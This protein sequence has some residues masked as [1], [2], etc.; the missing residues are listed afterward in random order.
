LDGVGADGKQQKLF[1]SSPTWAIFIAYDRPT[2]VSQIVASLNAPGIP[3]HT[4]LVSTKRA[5]L[6][7]FGHDIPAGDLEI[8]VRV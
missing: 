3:P 4:V 8:D 7:A 6:I 5:C 1:E 2:E